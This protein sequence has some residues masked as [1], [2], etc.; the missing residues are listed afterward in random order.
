MLQFALTFL[1]LCFSLVHPSSYNNIPEKWVPELRHHCP[2]TSI[3][4]IGTK[5]DMR[6]DPDIN[7]RL[8]ENNEKPITKEEGSILQ[9]KINAVAVCKW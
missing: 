6:E 4:L 2:Y 1:Q 7:R 8:K 5:Q 3:V 9:K